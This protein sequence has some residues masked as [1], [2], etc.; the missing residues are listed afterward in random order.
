VRRVCKLSWTWVWIGTAIGCADA[1]S[2]RVGP[3]RFIIHNVQPGVRYDVYKETK[4]RLTV[5]NDDEVDRTWSLSTHRPSEKGKWET[6]YAEIPSATWCWF[7]KDELV[8]PAGERA[9]AH[10]FLEIPDEERYYNQQWVVT[11]SVGGKTTRPGLSLAA[12][13]RV[14]IETKASGAVRDPPYGEMGI[15]PTVIEVSDPVPGEDREVL[16][17]LF[18]NDTVSHT[19][20]IGSLFDQEGVQERT[21]LTHSFGRIPDSGWVQY[22]RTVSVD[23][24]T[25][26]PL[27]ARI[28]IPHQPEGNVSKWEEI[29]LIRPDSGLARMARI[30]LVPPEER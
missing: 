29:L 13:I 10:L 27:V 24:G 14:Q 21:Y 17:R 12:D 7:D 26:V 28:E 11:L 3:A 22:E 2:L 1:A 16:W 30:Q 18:N 19:Y 5:S 23:P 8:V 15:A 25:S 20:E 9:Y 4:L 6:G